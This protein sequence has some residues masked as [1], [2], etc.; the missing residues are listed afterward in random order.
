M[1]SVDPEAIALL[2][3]MPSGVKGYDNVNAGEKGL[4]PFHLP[5]FSAPFLFVPPYLEVNYPTCSFIY[6]RHPT[7]RPGYSEI[8]TPY[9]ADGE[10][11]RFAWEWYVE[12]RPR[13]RSEKRLAWM[14]EDRDFDKGAAKEERE[15]VEKRARE[16]R[17]RE[18]QKGVI[19]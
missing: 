13:I 11:V 19:V 3:A 18:T 6:L 17:R 14:P 1:I 5:H 2:R 8:P 4:T 16:K 12:R 10:V 7:A 15:R 9:D